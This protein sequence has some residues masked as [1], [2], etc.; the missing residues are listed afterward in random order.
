VRFSSL[1]VRFA[2]SVTGMMESPFCETAWPRSQRRGTL[3]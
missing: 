3:R 2:Q 1:S